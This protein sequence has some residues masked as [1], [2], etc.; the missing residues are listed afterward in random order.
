M[1]FEDTR[2]WPRQSDRL[3]IREDRRLRCAVVVV[4]L[5]CS[6]VVVAVVVRLLAVSAIGG[7]AMTI[8]VCHS[9][10]KGKK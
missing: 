9:I 4:P 1:N 6:I 3:A 2:A 8:F 10:G 5:D 7:V